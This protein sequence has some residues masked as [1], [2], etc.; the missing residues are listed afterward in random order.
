MRGDPY[1]DTQVVTNASVTANVVILFI[2]ITS[3]HFVK[4]SC[5]TKRYFLPP[6]LGGRGPTK[7]KATLSKGA[8]ALSWTKGCLP[9]PGPGFASWQLR[10]DLT[11]LVR[12]FL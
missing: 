12:S 7:S 10:Q 8:P 4:Q 6:P 1:L 11:H 9:L 5:I 3:S 2:G